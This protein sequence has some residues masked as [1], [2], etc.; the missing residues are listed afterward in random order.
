MS[1]R[2]RA[3]RAFTLIELL[4]VIAIIAILIALLLPAVQQAR[5]AAKRTQ[6]KNN[7]KQIGLAL[8]NYH[9]TFGLFPP[10]Q[11]FDAIAA[12]NDKD[13]TVGGGN[14]CFPGL[15]SNQGRFNGAPW[16]VLI[17]PYIEQANLYQQFNLA[18][19]FFGRVD[20]QNDPS[21]N[22]PIQL[23]DSPSVF[24]CPTN[25]AFQSD[26]YICCYSA[27]MGGGGPAFKTDPATGQ[28][29]VDGTIPANTPRDNNPFSVNRMM[30]CWNPNP[31]QTLPFIGVNANFRPLWNNGPMHLNSSRSVGSIRDGTSNQVLVGETLFVG[32]ASNYGDGES[33]HPNLQAAYWTWASAVRPVGSITSCCPVLFNT[34]GILCGMNKPCI[35][36]TLQIAKQRGGAANGH[37]MIME[38]YS[39]WHT[40]GGHVTLG[41]GS[42]RFISENTELTIQQKM[43]AINDGLVLGEF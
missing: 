20:Y 8:H 39:S 19:P 24:R 36:Y 31:A 21:V 6:C 9:D 12:G 32:L 3:R 29:A 33:D 10:A 41:D 25:P 26:R 5:E 35:E 23:K 16:T 7:M 13:A 40:G 14:T 4:V 17:L 18:Q 37:S 22:Y 28:P 30:P 42:V 15:Y 11:I 34:V 27:C 2:S 43:G 38:G 1:R